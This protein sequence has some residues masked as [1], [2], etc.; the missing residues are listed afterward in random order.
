MKI[1][2]LG[3]VYLIAFAIASIGAGSGML[4]KAS[5]GTTKT[6]PPTGPTTITHRKAGKT[7]QEFMSHNPSRGLQGAQPLPTQKLKGK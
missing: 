7:Q 5:A 2:K 1:F 3:L 6:P 4:P